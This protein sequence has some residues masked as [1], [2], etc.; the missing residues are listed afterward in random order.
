MAN[1]EEGC[2]SMVVYFSQRPARRSR[3]M[4][5]WAA[6]ASGLARMEL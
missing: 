5:D 3:F 6:A 2:A 1:P 4:A